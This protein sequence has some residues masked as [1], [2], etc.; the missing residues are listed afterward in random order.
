MPLTRTK[1]HRIT[2]LNFIIATERDKSISV[3]VFL[4][5]NVIRE[6]RENR[7]LDPLVAENKTRTALIGTPGLR[8]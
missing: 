2:E 8:T 5:L 1:N 4:I 7:E 6:N 3:I